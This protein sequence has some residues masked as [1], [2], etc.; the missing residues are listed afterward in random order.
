MLTI[1]ATI[2]KKAQRVNSILVGLKLALR[3]PEQFDI[4]GVDVGLKNFAYCRLR[5]EGFL[6][7]LATPSITE[8]SKLDL[9]EAFLKSY[10]PMLDNSYTSDTILTDNLLDSTRYL[11]H[12]SNKVVSEV[13]FPGAASNDSTPTVAVIEHQRTRSV[14]QSSTLPNVMNNSLLEHMMLASFYARDWLQC[15]VI[16]VYAQSMAHFWI[17]RFAHELTKDSKKAM[18]KHSKSLR[19]RLVYHWINRSIQ[20]CGMASEH[21]PVT[22][23]TQ[24]L[25]TL[26]LFTSKP[27]IEFA[28]KPQKLLQMLQLDEAKITNCKVDDLVDS[29]LHGLSYYQYHKNKLALMM[30]LDKCIGVDK[31][32]EMIDEFV[33]ARTSAQLALL[34]DLI[35][36]RNDT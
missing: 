23:G 36:E 34:N 25:A 10:Q 4:V 31:P 28:N 26:D 29:L 32:Q 9:H 15:M 5:A 24:L 2:A 12:L 11:S 7:H 35:I 16:P 1:S 27:F 6:Q 8:W 17:N 3:L 30:T 18:A 22:L 21:S 20:A 14:G 19:T 33:R 13:L